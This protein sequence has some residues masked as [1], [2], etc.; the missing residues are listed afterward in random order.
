MHEQSWEK[1]AHSVACGL[2]EWDQIEA[3][4]D[5]PVFWRCMYDMD[6]Y[7]LAR[8]LNRDDPH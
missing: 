5:S 2:I 1:T 8:W 6:T 4:G 7:D 3:P